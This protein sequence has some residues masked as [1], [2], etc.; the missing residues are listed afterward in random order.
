MSEN[1]FDKMEVNYFQILLIDVTFYLYHVQKVVLDV[2]IKKLKTEYMRHRRL[3]AK[4]NKYRM[5]SDRFEFSTHTNY[6]KT[7]EK[8]N[9][10]N[11]EQR[12][13]FA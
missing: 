2:L 6:A 12:E 10:S 13:T 4:D 3:K 11:A 5:L 7:T 1:Y 9:D 8:I